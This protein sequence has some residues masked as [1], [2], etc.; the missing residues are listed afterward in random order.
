MYDLQAPV[1]PGALIFPIAL[2][3]SVFYI[4][5]SES[6]DDTTIDLRDKATGVVVKLNLPGQHAA[7]AVI[8]K[9]GK[10]VVAKYGF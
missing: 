5:S 10:A 6:A 9:T 8:S 3:D 4:M 7:L 2:E 1:S